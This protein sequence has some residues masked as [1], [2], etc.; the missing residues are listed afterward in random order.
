MDLKKLTKTNYFISDEDEPGPRAT[1]DTYGENAPFFNFFRRIYWPAI[2][3]IYFLG[4]SIMGAWSYSWLIFVLA[5]PIYSFIMERG[6]N[7]K[8]D[9][10]Q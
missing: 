1:K 10:E 5:G 4:S 2:V 6:Q 8:E 7:D 3:V 9:E